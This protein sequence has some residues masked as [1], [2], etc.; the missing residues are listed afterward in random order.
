MQQYLTKADTREGKYACAKEEANAQG[1]M[2]TRKG[3]SAQGQVRWQFGNCKWGR[4]LMTT[5]G[6]IVKP[7]SGLVVK[8]IANECYRIQFAI[9]LSYRQPS[10]LHPLQS[11]P[12]IY[13]LYQTALQN[14]SATDIVG[15]SIWHGAILDLLPFGRVPCHLAGLCLNPRSRHRRPGNFSRLPPLFAVVERVKAEA[16]PE[17]PSLLRPTG[18]APRYYSRMEIYRSPK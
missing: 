1:K 10:G 6:R 18:R 12:L 3:R 4:V 9:Y 16:T 2:Q 7:S 15:S 13:R 8:L 11:R 5:N 14:P 17:R